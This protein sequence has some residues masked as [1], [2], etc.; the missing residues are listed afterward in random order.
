MS[1]KTSQWLSSKK[2]FEGQ[3]PGNAL[4]KWLNNPDFSPEF[5]E[6]LLLDAQV[7]FRGI[8]Q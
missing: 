6:E 3:K 8:E 7:V 5:L 2:Q 1:N 4:A